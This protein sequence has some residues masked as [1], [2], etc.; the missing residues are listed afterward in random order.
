MAAPPPR[1]LVTSPPIGRQRFRRDG[2]YAVIDE[3]RQSAGGFGVF[4][5]VEFG[6]GSGF[7][8]GWE[9]WFGHQHPIN[10]TAIELAAGK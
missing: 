10:E 1:S 3:Q 6:F 8:F 4:E 7:G 9:D 5:F 2:G